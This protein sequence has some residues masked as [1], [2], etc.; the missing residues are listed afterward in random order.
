MANIA[1]DIK[2]NTQKALGEFKKLSRELDNKFLVQG[3]KL[4]VVKGA[5]AQINKEFENA[6]GQQGL[7]SAESAGQLQRNLALQLTTLGRFGRN[8][9][10]VVS[11]DV[12]GA[13]Q[14]L[15]AEG[16]ITAEV[17]QS[18]MNLS[19]FLDFDATGPELQRKLRDS[20]KLIAQFVQDSQDLFASDQAQLITK[21]VTGEVTFDE[22]LKLSTGNSGGA[23]NRFREILKQYAFE[24]NSFDPTIR[25]EAYLKAIEEFKQDPAFKNSLQDIKPIE[26]V[27]RE[28]SGLFSDTGLFGALRTVGEQ[29]PNFDNDGLLD[30]NL[31]Q[32]TGKLLRTIFD[33]EDGVFAKLN[34]ALQQAF[35]SFDVLE[36]ILSG[37]TF[38]TEVFEKLGNFFESSEFQSFLN[39]FDGLVDG[40]KAIFSGGGIDLSA[41][42]INKFIDGIF[43]AIKG[44]LGKVAEFIGGIDASAVG[45]VL[46]N[47]ASELVGLIGPLFGVIGNALVKLVE[48]GLSGMASGG[49][50][51]AA[52]I[53]AGG[54]FAANRLTAP[55]VNLFT[56]R[57]GGAAGI[58]GRRAD[59]RVRQSFFN[60]GT[61]GGTFGQRSGR[62][63]R[64]LGQRG[65]GQVDYSS[66][67]PD[68]ARGGGFSGFQGEVIRKFNQ[69]IIIMRKAVPVYMADMR[70]PQKNPMASNYLGR[71]SNYAG[72]RR[73]RG[74]LDTITDPRVDDLERQVNR[75]G[76]FVPRG[77]R[78]RGIF[79]RLAGFGGDILAGGIGD[80]IT[81]GPDFLDYGEPDM[82]FGDRGG[83]LRDMSPA[84]RAR[85]NRRFGL[86]GRMASFGRGIGRNLGGLKGAGIAGAAAGII[87]LATLFG[88]A[89]AQARA[90]DE[91]DR[92]SPEEKEF[93]KKENQKNAK[94]EAGRA[95]IGMAGGALGGIIGS[96]FGPAGTF[97]GG[98]LGQQ[99]GDAVSG[100]LGPEVLEAV[101]GFVAEI[102]NFFGDLWGNVV[103]IGGS[104]VEG[105][106][107][108]FGPEGPIAS[109]GKFL[110]EIP[111][112]ILKTI[113]DKFE[114]ARQGFADLPGNLLNGIKSFFGAG[115]SDDTGQAF[116]GGA[117]T[118]MT[119]VGENGPELVNLGSGANVI[120]NSS[121]VG[122]LYGNIGR[123]SSLASNTNYITVNVSAP[124]ADQF[125]QQLTDAVI[126]ELDR[127]YNL[128]E[129]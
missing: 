116:L 22:F 44:L 2:A 53:G 1:L 71:T 82:D 58:I 76:R 74:P 95:A 33:R 5:F 102:G 70:I 87:T 35:G 46:G 75:G 19:G 60:S 45:S 113:Q 57:E 97:I 30:R 67:N 114:E 119:L 32:V 69:I 7:K 96:F 48:V 47:I 121:I 13:L 127:Q 66:G 63:L 55:L 68:L 78:R 17:L 122:G 16:K 40:I 15:R 90:I 100:F 106:K 118:G 18:S 108:F 29:I 109:I 111:G 26:S 24:L 80:F 51:G 99:L 84:A 12:L 4:D 104:F 6:V 43:G 3:L 11:K 61:G 83:R 92:L 124:G 112:N 72:P 89:N 103:G 91:D 126:V 117:K 86:R 115:D 59:Q 73:G 79:G 34:K 81:G 64:G 77:R 56:R 65:G 25:T 107:N 10:D 9:A 125:A 123:S 129:A 14:D 88:G 50:G 93:F 101:G 28:L 128:Q 42:S 54:L 62:F 38:L 110:Y 31:L 8:A 23:T 36:P 49:L 27:F 85:Y 20:T 98:A 52:L 39:I 105:F 41:E 37:V 21:A 94:Q 120:P